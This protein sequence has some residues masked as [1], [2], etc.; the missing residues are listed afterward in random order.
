MISNSITGLGGVVATGTAG[1][2]NILAGNNSYNGLTTVKS[3]ALV[4]SGNDS[5]TTGTLAINGGTLIVSGAGQLDGGNDPDNIT[6]N[7]TFIYSGTNSQT[8]S[9]FIFGTGGFTLSSPTN[10]VVT[11]GT[12]NSSTTP[13]NPYTYTGPT[14][15]NSGELDLNF[16]NAG[17]SGL[18]LSSGLTINNGGKVVALGSS[19]LEGYTAQTA[20]LPVTINA[21]GLLTANNQ[22]IFAA[23]LYGVLTLNGGTLGDIAVPD[24]T[25]G[26]WD[27]N[28]KVVVN[29]GTNTSYITDPYCIPG[30]AG[31]TIFNVTN[32]GTASGIDLD[33]TGSFVGN[34]TGS[35]DTGVILTNNG[36]MAYETTNTYNNFTGIGAGA[37]LILNT[38]ALML[39][40]SFASYAGSITNNGTF[41]ENSTNAQVFRGVIS[42]TGTFNIKNPLASLTLANANTFAGSVIV[43]QGILLVSNVTGSAT[44]SGT[45]TVNNG[46]KLGG[47]GGSISGNVTFNPGSKAV[48]NLDTTF[49]SAINDQFSFNGASSLVTPSNGVVGINV[50]N[51]SLDTSDYVLM[52]Y[53]PGTIAGVFTNAPVWLGTVPGN[54]ANYSIVTLSNTVVLHYATGGFVLSG[55]ASPNPAARNA[56]VTFTVTATGANPITS[57]T[58]NA[59]SIGGSSAVTMVSAG[60]NTWTNSVA[61]SS[62]TPAGG[63]VLPFTVQDNQ[64]NTS[65]S[66]IALTVLPAI[67]VWT[68]GGSANT[69]AT[70]ANW[71]SGLGPIYGDILNFAGTTQTNVNMEASY[72]IGSLTFSNNAGSF[73]FTNT[74][75]TLTL[76]GGVTNNSP[77]PQ[78]FNMPIILNAV[79]TF[80]AAAGNITVSNVISGAGGVTATGAATATN[81][82]VANNTY[83]GTTA[84]NGGTLELLGSETI[85]GQMSINAGTMLIAGGGLLN[86]GNFSGNVFDNGTLNY[87]STNS[88]QFTGSVFG[89]GGFTMNTPTN[90]TVTF[91]GTNSFNGNIVINSGIWSDQNNQNGTLNPPTSGLGNTTTNKT[92][93]INSGGVLSV[94]AGGFLGNGSSD[95]ALIFII[96]SNGLMRVTT[97]NSTMG[98]LILNGGKFD[99]QT[100]GYSQAFGAM[101]IGGPITVGGNSPSYITN[102]FAAAYGLNLAINNIQPTKTITVADVT[103]DS[104]VDLYITAPLNDSSGTGNPGN[105]TTVALIKAGPGTMLLSGTNLYSGGTIISAGTIIAANGDNL[106]AQTLTGTTGP[107]NAAG[108]ANSAG[109]LGKPGVVVTLGDTNTTASNASPALLIGGPFNVNHPITIST[110]PTTGI[111]TIG[112]RTDNNSSF[113][114]LVTL[115]QPLTISQVANTGTNALTFKGGITSGAA[116]TNKVTFAGPGNVVLT[117]TGISD[118]GGQLSVAVTGG[119]LFLNASNGY[120]GGTTVAG[121]TLA[122][123]GIIGGF[124]TNN[125]G[126]NLI[127]GKNVSAAGTVLTIS[128]LTMLAGSA[129]SFVVSHTLQLNDKIVCQSVSYGGTLN[130][131]TNAGDGALVAGDTFQLFNAAVSYGASSFSAINLPALGS[132]L[133]WNT[134]NLA[135]NG[136]ISVDSVVSTPPSFGSVRLSGGSLVLSGANGTPLAQYRILTS[137]NVALPLAS[138]TPVVTN[139][140]AAD[141]TYSYTNTAA[142][143]ARASSS[144][145]RRKADGFKL[146]ARGCPAGH[147][148]FFFRLGQLAR[149]IFCNF[150]LDVL[151][152]IRDYGSNRPL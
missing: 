81:L 132:G 71:L 4:L 134:S 94:D 123:N 46:G 2:T 51:G 146:I 136:S 62:T 40:S 104:N 145:S 10:T 5:I 60:G 110:N 99:A 53:V 55:S 31:G 57:V 144:W 108:G 152:K 80:N 65:F 130:V 35:A 45:V 100:S 73:N 44:G 27:I 96:N 122:G 70:G 49:N 92:V 151:S 11:I 83:T 77:N 114:N 137:T 76:N 1:Y 131:T 67:E 17:T 59:S 129:S 37:T 7:G 84:V 97:G 25:Y 43:N 101:A 120:S 28:N 139:A 14:L 41:I 75:N 117:T 150:T 24:P 47:H 64:G 66:S 140:F 32:G 42:G 52:N 135:V 121:G 91:T 63:G 50:L 147:P 86:G 8:F 56:L 103:G 95:S 124:V 68:G 143:N 74:V 142:T 16:N 93:T 72:T 149:R 29:G 85:F 26:G 113:S 88:Q 107:G 98:T 138:W 13:V 79:Q 90:V 3:G 36:T 126:G 15:V 20:N 6:N 69:W 19:A 141:G 48:F 39:S 34:F 128:N 78:A 33:I 109:A 102:T 125:A 54:P 9:G 116:S 58:L 38:N 30:E 87:S 89:N 148:R 12:G 23:H 127:P 22:S 106:T 119:T 111:Y 112:G 61:I 18:Y 82:L 21:G 118:G 105:I 133:A 115:N